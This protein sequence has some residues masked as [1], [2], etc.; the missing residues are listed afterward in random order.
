R[1]CYTLLL[2]EDFNLETG[3][4]P[5][6]YPEFSKRVPSPK[7]LCF[8]ELPAKTCLIPTAAEFDDG[9]VA[10]LFI[11][12]RE[13]LT[14]D[15]GRPSNKYPEIQDVTNEEEL[16]Q[17]RKE[18]WDSYSKYYCATKAMQCIEA[19]AKKHGKIKWIDF[20]LPVAA[21]GETLHLH[22]VANEEYHTGTFAY[23]F[24]KRFY[25]HG[26]KVVGMLKAEPDLNVLAIYEN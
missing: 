3:T 5:E 14:T 20:R 13:A 9:T 19:A 10:P 23:N 25:K 7:P 1:I 6:W 22:I 4:A 21:S 11:D 18:Y 8:F 17:K 2:I 26:G 16:L 24:V 15:D 12:L